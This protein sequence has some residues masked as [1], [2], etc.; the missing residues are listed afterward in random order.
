MTCVITNQISC[1]RLAYKSTTYCAPV[2]WDQMDGIRHGAPLARLKK[3]KD[4][5]EATKKQ[6]HK[7][8]LVWKWKGIERLKYLGYKRRRI[9]NG[10][11]IMRVI[12]LAQGPNWTNISRFFCRYMVHLSAPYCK[13]RTA[14][15]TNQNFPF[16][17]RPVRTYN[18]GLVITGLHLWMLMFSIIVSLK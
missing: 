12:E 3:L 2:Y 17:C 8:L 5:T 11:I 10:Y 9:T 6:Q 15:R 18:K 14:K 16:Y 13:I 7:V 4:K 1:K